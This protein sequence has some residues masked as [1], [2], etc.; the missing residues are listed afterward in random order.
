MPM[1]SRVWTLKS[2]RLMFFKN[3]VS[4]VKI[5]ETS[6]LGQIIYTANAMNSVHSQRDLCC[7]NFE[8]HQRDGHSQG[9]IKHCRARFSSTRDVQRS[10]E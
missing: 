3:C 7:H 1:Y 5:R 8:E 9:Y 6:S 10:T 4:V 2:R